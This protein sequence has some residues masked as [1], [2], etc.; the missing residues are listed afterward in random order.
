MVMIIYEEIEIF[1]SG[2]CLIGEVGFILGDVS[3][4]ELFVFHSTF[5]YFLFY[6]HYTLVTFRDD[7]W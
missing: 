6:V 4:E 2:L 5:F 7:V 3:A 1:Y